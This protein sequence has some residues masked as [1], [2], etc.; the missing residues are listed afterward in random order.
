[1]LFRSEK[2]TVK[3]FDSWVC[4]YISS[5]SLYKN[6]ENYNVLFIKDDINE[7]IDNLV[8]SSI[9]KKVGVTGTLK[10]SYE[11]VEVQP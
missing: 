5:Y 4:G 10:E 1:M 3:E 9:A 6:L 7:A 8:I 11:E 2:I